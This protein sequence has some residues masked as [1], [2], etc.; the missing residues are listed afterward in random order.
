MEI[1]KVLG[2]IV[3][4]W[5]IAAVL[6]MARLVRKGR[7]LMAVFATR[8]PETYEALGRPKPGFLQSARRSRF[9]EFISLRAYKDLCDPALCDQ[10]EE[11]RKAEVC[12]LLCSLV[13]LVIVG[14][15]VLTVRNAV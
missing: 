11:Y 6:L 8:Y 4:G 15:V 9:S 3:V 5:L 7:K 14:V 10:F 12:L 1:E 2:L 13:S